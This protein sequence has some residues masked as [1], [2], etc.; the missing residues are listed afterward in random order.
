VAANY[1][2]ASTR[3]EASSL[4]YLAVILLVMALVV[5]LLAQIIVHRFDP[6]RVRADE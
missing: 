3:L 1:Q 4:V 5:N 6:V 2:S